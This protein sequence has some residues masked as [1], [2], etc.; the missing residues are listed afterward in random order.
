MNKEILSDIVDA[1]LIGSVC[2]ILGIMIGVSIV[3][4]KR[5]T[6]SDT[7]TTYLIGCEK[8]IGN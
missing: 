8:V 1:I 5:V 6:T 3:S 7:T 2:I 4:V